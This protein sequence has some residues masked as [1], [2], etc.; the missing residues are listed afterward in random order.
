MPCFH[1]MKGFQIGLTRNG[2]PDY[3]R[4]PFTAQSVQ[5][6][7]GTWRASSER[8]YERGA[9]RI[10]T[11]YI[12]MPCGQCIGCRMDKSREWADRLVLEL[13]YHDSAYFVT[14]TYNNKH[15]PRR[16]YA[17]PE[18]G[19]A[20][21]SYSLEKRA[22]Q[23]LMKRIRRTFPNDNIRYY[24]CGE[25]GGKTF[26]PHYHMIIFGLHLDDLQFYKKSELGDT[27]WTSPKLS[28]CW[29][30]PDD[31]EDS[32]GYVVVAPV[33]W[34]TC[35]YVGR[36]VTKKL[37][38]KLAGFYDVHNIIPEFSLM[39]RKPGIGRAYYDDHP[40]LYDYKWINVSLPSG[41]RKIRP[42]R[43][44]DRLYDLDNPAEFAE[45]KANRQK[46]A[47]DLVKLKLE[48]T[49]LSYLELLEVEEDALK[50]KFKKLRRTLHEKENAPQNRPESI[51][52]NGAKE[53]K[54]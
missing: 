52:S 46:M 23:L 24:C 16:W 34:E 54:D 28:S 44:Y 51:L 47:E 21:E 31:K 7:N 40:N 38:G 20:F 33:T 17:D 22:I 10:V 2:K 12:V 35:A 14:F 13:Q 26:R 5:R 37:T 4:V 43:Y 30:D 53:Q 32:Y 3:K 50:E 29:T 45:I 27:Y 36:Y 48:Q 49:D 25:Y 6:V 9:D 18:T 41:G 42:P 15:V 1:P 8:W 19:E 39:S 11:D